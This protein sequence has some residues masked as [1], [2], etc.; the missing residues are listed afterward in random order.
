MNQPNPT[1]LIDYNSQ[2]DILNRITL[3]PDTSRK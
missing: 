1:P 3:K 2:K